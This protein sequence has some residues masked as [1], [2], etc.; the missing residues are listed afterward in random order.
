MR[1]RRTAAAAAVVVAGWGE[2][3]ARRSRSAHRREVEIREVPPGAVGHGRGPDPPQAEVLPRRDARRDA[4]RRRGRETSPSQ[5]HD[6]S[7]VVGVL[8]EIA[9]PVPGH[10]GGREPPAEGG[11]HRSQCQHVRIDERH[12]LLLLLLRRR[13][14][15]AIIRGVDDPIEYP[16]RLVAVLVP[17]LEGVRGGEIHPQRIRRMRR[18]RRRR[19]RRA[20]TAPPTPPP[21]Q[22]AQLGPNSILLDLRA[23]RGDAR[24]PTGVTRAAEGVVRRDRLPVLV[25]GAVGREDDVRVIAATRCV[26]VVVVAVAVVVV[27]RRGRRRRRQRGAAGATAEIGALVPSDAAIGG[28]DDRRRGG[29]EIDPDRGDAVVEPMQSHREA[30]EHG[31][32]RRRQEGC[33]QRGR[34]DCCAR[35][36]QSPRPWPWRI[37]TGDA[38]EDGGVVHASP[39]PARPVPCVP[40][41]SLP[42]SPSFSRRVLCEPTSR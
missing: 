10:G 5:Q 9:I 28:D 12:D 37:G 22:H 36:P 25:A 2:V 8:D 32:P 20:T 4:G 29:D 18:R 27:P 41:L 39:A 11:Y 7:H 13:C 17:P 30:E 21:P 31:D 26:V 3:Q 16:P 33:H 35:A 6:F 24:D 38:H 19:R 34:R 1:R 23:A 14:R 15:I 40:P 42:P